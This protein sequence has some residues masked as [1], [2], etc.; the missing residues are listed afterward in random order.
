MQ[1]QRTLA[2]AL[3]AGLIA[4]G[5]TT[6]LAAAEKEPFRIGAV[7]PLTGAYSQYGDFTEKGLRV[8]VKQINEM[9]GILGR[10][11]ELVIR[12]D[13][14]NP[15]RALLAAKELLSEQEVDFLYPDIISG[16]ALA[17]VPY[18]TEEKV[19]T[20][21]N[22]ASPQIGDAAKFPYSF[23]YADLATKR[24]PAMAAALKK[25]GGSKVGILVSTNPPQVALGDGLNNDLATK[26]GMEVVGYDKFS[27]DTKDL[28]PQ[29]QGLRDAGADI[30]AFD[31]GARDN[32]RVVMTGMQTLGW[33]ANVVTEPAALYGDLTAQ[34]PEAVQGQFHAVNYRIGT[35][36]GSTPEKVQAFIDEMK[37]LGPIQNLAIGAI[38][39]DAM[40]LAKWAFETAQAESG[41]TTSDSLKR[42][43]E[44]LHERDYPE[45]Y[46]LSIGNP[47]Y[48]PQDHTTRG[49]DYSSFWG[50][51]HVSGLVD[52]TYAGELLEVAD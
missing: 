5:V 23:Q 26:Y 7:I 42:A 13:A 31:T 10:P 19:F 29:L 4:L 8:G 51:I 11:V 24:I 18:T 33:G 20:I 2:A 14:G 43:M 34:V 16:M 35:R 36:T 3:S 32:V 6:S 40:F 9:G 38:A 28:A 44:S 15:G 49:A 30:V 17:I 37:A 12:D 47:R 45:A 21:A 39:R 22:G 48:S 52:G 50:L 46:S 1:S 25:L 27:V 41:D